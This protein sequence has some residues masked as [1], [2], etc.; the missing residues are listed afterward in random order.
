M[1]MVEAIPSGKRVTLGGDKNYD[2]Q[3]FV[4]ELRGMNT[5]G[6]LIHRA[7]AVRIVLRHMWGNVGSTRG[8]G[9]CSLHWIHGRAAGQCV[10]AS[11]GFAPNSIKTSIV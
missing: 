6:P 11:V 2:T 7:P 5:C 4:R 3:E 9:G 8:N 10:Q 1:L